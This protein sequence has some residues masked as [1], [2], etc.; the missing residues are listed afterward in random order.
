MNDN[1]LSLEA[2]SLNANLTGLKPSATV[3]SQERSNRLLAEGRQIFRM[4]LG[5]SPF[6][7]PDSVVAALKENAHQK[8]Y[9]PVKGLTALRETLAARHTHLFNEPCHADRVLI[10]PGSKELMFILQLVFEGDVLIPSPAWV[11][12]AP[13][14]RIIG[15]RVVSIA[16]SAEDQWRLTPQQLEAVCREDPRRKRLLILNYPSNPTGGSYN[17]ED[18]EALALACR[19]H[20]VIVLSDEIYSR[21]RFEGE[22]QSMVPLYPEGTIYSSGLSK[23]CGAGGWRLGTFIFPDQLSWIADAMAIVASETFTSTSAPIQHAAVRAFEDGPEI[24]QYLADS[25]QI[26]GQL[27][28]YSHSSL[29]D[30]GLSTV[31]PLG[32]FYCFPDFEVAR[33]A[34]AARGILHSAELTEQLLEDT[35]VAI[36]PGV[37]FGRPAT[38]LTARIAYV[39]FDGSEALAALAANE[40]KTPDS[41]F[42]RAHCGNTIEAIDRIVRWVKAL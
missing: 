16:T 10:G 11:S 26:L 30:N 2:P 17:R 5:Q 42:L 28:R 29:E 6:P 18:L 9:L 14:A 25:Q 36:L 38:E 27:A 3:A 1:D 35:G 41:A 40:R 24:K 19:R 12:Y 21:L 34:L 23:W 8:D 39:D 31:R 33:D 7:V 22:H 37:E 15:R 4:G 20:G 32:G 13:Q